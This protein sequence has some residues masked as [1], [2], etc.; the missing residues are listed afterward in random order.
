MHREHRALAEEHL[1]SSVPVP[2]RLWLE[3]SHGLV[4][5]WDMLRFL[6]HDFVAMM[7]NL[8][9]I[10]E[11]LSSKGPKGLWFACHEPSMR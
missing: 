6:A 7:H 4:S 11:K 5:L 1:L 8:R 2:G 9:V 3:N 10:E